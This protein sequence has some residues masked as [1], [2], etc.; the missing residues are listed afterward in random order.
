MD[1]T[2]YS[3]FVVAGLTVAAAPGPTVLQIFAQSLTG[4]IRRPV[5]LIAGSLLANALM[6]SATVLGISAVIL[7]SQTAFDIMR[8]IGSAY[9]IYLGIQYWRMRGAVLSPAGLP[10]A[11]PYRVLFFQAALTSLTNPK[12]LV[13]YIAF[14]PQFVAPGGDPQFQLAVLGA[15]YIL[16]CLIA[17]GGYVLAGRMLT[18]LFTTPRAMRITN[19]LTGTALIAAGL[20][21]LRVQRSA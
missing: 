10:P 13:F 14:L 7:A 2:H 19:R 6:V 12:G 18:R 9:L 11:K 1:W 5:S 20:S 3:L 15:S 4:D 17:D 16:L 21:L 8:W